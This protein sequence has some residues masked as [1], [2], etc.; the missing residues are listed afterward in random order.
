AGG[1]RRGGRPLRD[2]KSVRPPHSSAVPGRLVQR[3]N[4][5]DGGTPGGRRN[6]GV[7]NSD[8]SDGVPASWRFIRSANIPP[9]GR[10]AVGR[11][12]VFWR[13]R[14]PRVQE[15]FSGAVR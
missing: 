5:Q 12:C 4:R 11:I 14:G 6:S 9:H 15:D 8:R 13:E 3:V 2:R 7:L 10:T 1:R